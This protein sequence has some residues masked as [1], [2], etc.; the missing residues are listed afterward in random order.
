MFLE[1]IVLQLSVFTV[2]ATCNVTEPMK[3]VLFFYISTVRSMCAVPNT[4]FLGRGGQFPNFVL[5]L[6]VA[7]VFF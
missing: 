7:Q 4:A 2:C 6:F 1:Y 3:Y 5:F